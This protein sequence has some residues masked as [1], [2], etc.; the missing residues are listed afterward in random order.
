MDPMETLTINSQEGEQEFEIVDAQA[1]EDISDLQQNKADKSEIPTKVSELQNDEGYITNDVDGDLDVS[2]DVHADNVYATGAIHG[3]IDG[4]VIGTVRKL[5]A[6]SDTRLTSANFPAAGDNTLE[7]FNATSSIP[8]DQGDP[9]GDAHVLKMNWD[10]TGGWDSMMAISNAGT[11]I[12]Q[13][14]TAL[15]LRAMNG[16][17]GTW[18]DWYSLMDL[19][20]PVGAVCITS[21]NTNPATIF[22][23]GTWTL[24]HKRFKYQIVENVITFNSTNTQSGAS[25]AVINGEQIEI[26]LSFA[27]KVDLTDAVIEIGQLNLAAIGLS[28][29][30]AE[31]VPFFADAGNGI[32]F[33]QVTNTGLI[34]TQEVVPKGTATTIP[35]GTSSGQARL[36]VMFGQGSMLDS[37][38]DEF[39]WV[40]TA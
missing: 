26:R 30:Y 35:A 16:S 10:N 5:E 29:K 39:H 37:F 25:V 17:S 28:G 9:G 32:A 8:A 12:G 11:R 24:T 40:R 21:T 6:M 36:S 33:L 34:Q 20:Y 18:S 23:G 15:L 22:G 38:C 4:E 1:R 31:Y 13:L 3:V 2:G 7:Y 27:N 19:V 14:A